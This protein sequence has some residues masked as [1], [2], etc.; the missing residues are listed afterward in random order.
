ME[1]CRNHIQD[2]S[3][4]LYADLW[5]PVFR[6]EFLELFR[7]E[8]VTLL[9]CISL[10]I[11]IVYSP[12]M[13]AQVWG[14]GSMWA[15]MQKTQVVMYNNRLLGTSF[16]ILVLFKEVV[17]SCESIFTKS[18]ENVQQGRAKNLQLFTVLYKI[19]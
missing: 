7:T 4:S 2:S 3:L 6:H 18:R 1:T 12:I 14:Y 16:K 13:Q 5:P 9:T 11:N 19:R 10:D 17:S 8:Y 15:I